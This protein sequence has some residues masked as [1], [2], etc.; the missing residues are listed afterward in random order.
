MFSAVCVCVYVDVCIYAHAYTVDPLVHLSWGHQMHLTSCY[1]G[2][3]FL[4][5]KCSQFNLEHCLLLSWLT[6]EIT[7]DSRER[8]KKYCTSNLE[9]PNTLDSALILFLNSAQ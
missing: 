5:Q 1:V 2:H 4:I 8:K 9:A 7:R 6:H 3:S